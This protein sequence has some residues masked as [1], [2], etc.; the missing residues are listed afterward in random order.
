MRAPPSNTTARIY[1]LAH[2]DAETAEM[3]IDAAI[4][5]GDGAGNARVE[6][7]LLSTAAALCDVGEP[8]ARARGT[9]AKTAC[10]SCTTAAGRRTSITTT[11]CAR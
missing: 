5:R 7:L 6:I 9:R 11:C 2:D 4:A 8:R 1:L 10:A 3:L